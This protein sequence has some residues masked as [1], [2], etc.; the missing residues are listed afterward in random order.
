[1]NISRSKSQKPQFHSVSFITRDEEK[2]LASLL[3]R[4]TALLAR[5]LLETG[6]TVSEGLRFLETYI[7]TE[8]K[9]SDRKTS[10]KGQQSSEIATLPA[11]FFSVDITEG[12]RRRGLGVIP[13]RRVFCR[14]RLLKEIGTV[15]TSTRLPGSSGL[16]GREALAMRLKRASEAAL[17]K[18]VTPAVLRHTCAARLFCAGGNLITVSAYMGHASPSITAALYLDAPGFPFPSFP[19]QHLPGYSVPRDQKNY[20]DSWFTDL[21]RYLQSFTS[22]PVP[23]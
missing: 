18:S 11:G 2:R 23:M 3:N 5:F 12:R 15:F 8:G 9:T 21:V 17:Q 14:R 7:A 4:D 19:E 6:C 13:S 1:M 16:P 20:S 22:R 10:D